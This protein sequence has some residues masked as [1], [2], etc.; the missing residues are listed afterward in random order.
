MLLVAVSVIG[1]LS[2]CLLMFSVLLKQ[3]FD[4]LFTQNLF[5]RDFLR[6]QPS[7]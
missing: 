6:K 4:N 5:L 7:G 3:E 2:P 1:L